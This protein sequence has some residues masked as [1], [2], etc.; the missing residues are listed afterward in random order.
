MMCH[1]VAHGDLV[2]C[3]FGNYVAKRAKLCHRVLVTAAAIAIPAVELGF[4]ASL[5]SDTP[6]INSAFLRGLRDSSYTH[7]LPSETFF[8]CGRQAW[9]GIRADFQTTVAH[10][11][12]DQNEI[13]GYVVHASNDDGVAVAWIY[14]AKPW[15]KLGVARALI[16]RIGI[17]PGRKFA[18]LF[19]TPQKLALARSK[20]LQPAFLP[21][22]HWRWLRT[23]VKAAPVPTTI[24]QVWNGE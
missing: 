19:A 16:E 5:P 22:L 14:V 18:V 21:F 23:E 10:P 1:V 11:T 15:R 13:A 7:G 24:N 3:R 17:K 2:A 12:S 9:E 6:A 8:A 4:R 20:G